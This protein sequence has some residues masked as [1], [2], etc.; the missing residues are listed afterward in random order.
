VDPSGRLGEGCG[1]Q[2]QI[3]AV[4]LRY[5]AQHFAEPG[6]LGEMVPSL[7]IPKDWL[8][9]SF[10][11]IRGM[12]PAEALFEHRLN[13]L[14]AALSAQ[15]RQGLRRAIVACG[16]SASRNVVGQFEQ[17]FGIEMS[18]FLLTCR[19]A[20]EDRQFGRRHPEQPALIQGR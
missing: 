5:F 17:A 4:G 11:Q 19:R 13:R 2:I 12:T 16:L 10:E 8:D 14:F 1:T 18:L 7:G 15:P 20:A 6:A 3:V 9:F